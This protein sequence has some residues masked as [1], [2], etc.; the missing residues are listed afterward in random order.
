MPRKRKPLRKFLNLEL[1]E[2]RLCLSPTPAPVSPPDASAQVQVTRSYGQL[3]LSFEANQGQ[4][5]AQVNFLSRGSGCSLFLSPTQAGLDLTPGS[6]ENILTMQLVGS[7]P[8]A[9]VVGLNQLPG[10]SNYLIGNDPAQ[11]HTNIPNYARV[12]YENVYPGVNLAYY[13]NNQQHLEYDF[14]LAPGA[15]PHAIKL[16]FQGAQGMTLDAQ[17]D[18]V[19]HTSGGDI[20]E[21]APVLYQE[22]NGVR[23]PVSGRYV[24][25]GDGQVGFQIEAYA[26]SWPLVI[27]PTYSLVYSTYL[28]GNGDDSGY[29]IAVDSAGNAYITGYTTSTN[30]AT[31]TP[32]QAANAGGKDVFVT[33]LNAAGNGLLY[34][35]YLG[36]SGDDV[37][38]RIALDSSGNAYVT[39]DTTST[40]FPTTAGAFQTTYA[41][42]AD[43]FVAKLNTTGAL[44][45]STYLGGSGSDDFSRIAV[46]G[47]GNAYVAMSTGSANLPVSSPDPSGPF[48]TSL[49]AVGARDGYVAKLN[50]TGS[51]LVYATYLGATN[52]ASV[53][54]IAVDTAGDA[55]LTGNSLATFPT[56]PNAFQTTVDG[57]YH[58][59][60]T[61]MNVTGSGLLYSTYLAG[62]TYY[63][64]D[65]GYETGQA[66]AVDGSGN[67]YVTGYTRS[68]DFP[69]KNAFQ[70]VYGGGYGDAF[71]AKLNPALSGTASLLYSSYLGGSGPENLSSSNSIMAGIAVGTAGRIYLT[72]ATNSRNFPAANA[73]QMTY[74][75]GASDG[76]V[77]SI[78][79][80]QIGAASLVYSSY[81][82]GRDG[83]AGQDIAVDAA[84]NAYVT[85][86]T[87]SKNFPTKGAFQGRNGGGLDAFVTKIDPPV[88]TANT[89]P[90]G[91]LTASA[92]GTD[93]LIALQ[94]TRPDFSFSEREPVPT[95]LLNV[96]GLTAKVVGPTLAMSRNDNKVESNTIGP[97]PLDEGDLWSEPVFHLMSVSE[98]IALTLARHVGHSAEALPAPNEEVENSYGVFGDPFARTLTVQ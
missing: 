68:L 77:A 8:A 42:N 43:A 35:T 98:H 80:S 13:G 16:S 41:G 46:D 38:Y 49:D 30:F 4:T 7:N 32:W 27:D 3:P 53:Y 20:V 61:E 72:G 74:G 45:Y 28:G 26:P 83:D 37:G 6:T 24:L 70:Q 40:N 55:Y 71:V 31:K 64:G 87:I 1:L 92:T 88:D 66:I 89:S 50:S 18:L 48:Q 97:G 29:G 60:V 23:Q 59:F 22:A 58:V 65:G 84:G 63:N 14:V 5:D 12:E 36:G 33:K 57:A 95:A 69:T 96:G 54:G 78:D 15:D 76:F 93:S 44:V 19:L 62:T 52:G 86:Y 9:Q 73:F 47:S 82:G 67:A 51:G 81:L 85:G 11:W 10:V 90:S 17:G 39:G 79:T 34:S 2:D 21:Q 25:E 75:G 56:T 94:P 91:S